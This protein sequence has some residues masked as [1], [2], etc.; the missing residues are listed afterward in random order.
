MGIERSETWEEWAEDDSDLGPPYVVNVKIGDATILTGAIY[1]HD[2]GWLAEIWANPEGGNIW[3]KVFETEIFYPD[4]EEG[5][6]CEGVSILTRESAA[7]AIAALEAQLLVVMRQIGAM[8]SPPQ[9]KLDRI[10]ALM[11]R[12][13]TP[14]E[15]AEYIALVDEVEAAE[16]AILPIPTE[17]E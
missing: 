15:E 10:D 4:V 9:V 5:E 11:N 14:A 17:G 7:P 2:D 13:R 6:A 3:E 8:A 16:E 1:A 12:D